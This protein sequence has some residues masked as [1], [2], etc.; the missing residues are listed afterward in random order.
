MDF[1]QDLV[2]RLLANSWAVVL[3]VHSLCR[4]GFICGYVFIYL[5]F[6]ISLA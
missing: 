3:K 2:Y 6:V 4:Y 5:S 1:C